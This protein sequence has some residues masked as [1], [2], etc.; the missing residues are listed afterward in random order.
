MTR[1]PDC[2]GYL[3]CEAESGETAARIKCIACGWMR[4]D[5]N[6]RKE[7][8]KYFPTESVN[9]KIGWQQQNSGYDL[10]SRKSDPRRR[11]LN[12]WFEKRRRKQ[13]AHSQ[14]EYHRRSGLG[15]A[16]EFE[17]I[18]KRLPFRLGLVSQLMQIV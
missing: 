16:V 12:G 6:F 10:H 15:T 4:S 7:P 14:S 18:H 2:K 1:C 3:V 8:P 9:K 5:P 11:L 13:Q 17:S